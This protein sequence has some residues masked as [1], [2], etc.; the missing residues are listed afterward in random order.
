MTNAQRW[1]L[2]AVVIALAAGGWTVLS[3]DEAGT[4][5]RNAAV[6]HPPAIQQ[7]AHDVSGQQAGPSGNVLFRIAS[8][9]NVPVPGSGDD[10]VPIT[11]N[12]QAALDAGQAGSMVVALPDGTR[13]PVRY[14]RSE[15]APDGNW[16]FIGRVDTSIGA[17]ASVLTFGPDGMYVG[18]FATGQIQLVKGL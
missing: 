4:T 17:L 13:Y 10:S 12:R 11:I 3:A 18:D 16:T 6:A 9:R 7:L 2:A 14:E 1:T 5:A 15:S 8:S